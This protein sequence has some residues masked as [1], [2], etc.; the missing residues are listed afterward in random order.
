LFPDSASFLIFGLMA[1]VLLIR[2]WGM[3]EEE[4]E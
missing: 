1:L 4:M 3:L 2:S